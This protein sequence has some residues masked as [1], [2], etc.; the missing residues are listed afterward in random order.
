VDNATAL[1]KRHSYP[2][3][4]RVIM[5]GLKRAPGNT[6]LLGTLQQALVG[7][8]DFADGAKRVAASTGAYSQREYADA[9]AQFKS[10]VSAGASDRSEDK[11]SAVEHYVTAAQKYIDSVNSHALAMFKQGNLNGA[12]RAVTT[13][14]AAAPGD[15]DLRKT[16][17]E[18]LSGAEA[19]ANSAKLAAEASGAS[20]RPEYG[21]GSARLKSADISRRSGSSGDAEAALRDYVTA[22][23]LYMAAVNS[24][25]QG[26]MKQGN[27][28]GAARAIVAGLGVIPDSREF[29]KTLQEILEAAETS[30]A[31]ARRSTDVVAGASSRSE[32][33]NA[34]SQFRSGSNSRSSGRP[35]NA[36][37]AVRDYGAAEKLYKEAATA[38][39]AS[40]PPPVGVG[41]SVNTAKGLIAQGNLTGA[42]RTIVGGLE[43]N[44]KNS[45]LI[46]TLQLLYSAAEAEAT[47]ARKAADAAGAKERPEYTDANERLQTARYSSRIAGPENAE[48]IVREFGA[49]AELY[50]TAT[51]KVKT[52][53]PDPRALDEFAIRKLLA[54]YVEAYNSMDARRVRRF[55]PS[56]TGFP[57]ELSSTQLTITAVAVGPIVDR[58]SARVTV[59]AWYKNTYKKGAMSGVTLPTPVNL[60]WRVQRKGDAWILVE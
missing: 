42:A 31:A 53:G 21:D 37:A 18:I 57:S 60:T 30:A 44:P 14:L 56:F 49:A 25:V 34:T 16:L 38:A 35:E 12:A 15:A 22:S 28:A 4:A 51:A 6:D 50:R 48:A 7:A 5:E 26:V 55:K 11:A 43:D 36:E 59:T 54:D 33:V 40:P 32:Y 24:H 23:Q 29:Q 52:A 2:Q 58:L 45:D 46:G 9:D 10:A 41:P 8:R 13:G 39:A 27:L 20:S 3:A 19:S 47:N 1:I 17:Q